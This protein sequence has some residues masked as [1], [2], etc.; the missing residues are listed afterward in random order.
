MY[1]WHWGGVFPPGLQKAKA[2][3]MKG[4]GQHQQH[5]LAAVTRA[6]DIIFPN[7]VAGRPQSCAARQLH[8]THR[9]AMKSEGIC[10]RGDALLGLP[11]LPRDTY[12]L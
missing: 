11:V 8:T 10:A 5:L 2:M 4:S 1:A 9:G 3:N 12:K 7:R 6:P